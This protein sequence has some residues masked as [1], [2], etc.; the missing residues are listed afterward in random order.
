MSYPQ[1]AHIIVSLN[2]RKNQSKNEILSQSYLNCY[3]KKQHL[4]M[5]DG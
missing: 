2:L 3:F 4:D 5:I 1:I